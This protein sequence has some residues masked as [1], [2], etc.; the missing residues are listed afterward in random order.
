MEFKTGPDQTITVKLDGAEYQLRQPLVK[1][2]KRLSKMGSL[3][4][5]KILDETVN[6]LT[7]IGMPEEKLNEMSIST[8]EQLFSF[9]T[10]SKKN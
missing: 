3:G 7:E 6:F 1:D 10:S 8:L 2:L 9:I 4:N 5:D